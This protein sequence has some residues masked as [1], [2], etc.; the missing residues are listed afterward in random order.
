MPSL[1][2]A[3]PKFISSRSGRSPASGTAD[4][5]PFTISRPAGTRIRPTAPYLWTMVLELSKHL[6][7]KG[8]A[9][10]RTLTRAASPDGRV[11][12]ADLWILMHGFA[13]GFYAIWETL[14]NVEQQGDALLNEALAEWRDAHRKEYDTRAAELRK[15]LSHQGK[16]FTTLPRI[17]WKPD[18]FN[19]T[20]HPVHDHVFA[21]VQSG[22]DVAEVNLAEWANSIFW[23]WERQLSEIERIYNRKKRRSTDS[24]FPG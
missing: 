8:R 17:T 5:P 21:T 22:E 3:A 7:G 11:D 24:L 12:D 13:G 6:V 9:A 1:N 2:V 16:H 20:E 14:H 18:W 4:A 15:L 10:A 23:W 19:D